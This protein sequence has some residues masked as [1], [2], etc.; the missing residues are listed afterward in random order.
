MAIS[1]LVLENFRNYSSYT[2]NSDGKNVIITAPNGTGKT[3]I[4]E[5]ISTLSPGKSLR[6]S[7]SNEITN[8][9]TNFSSW[10]VFCDISNDCEENTVG[11]SYSGKKRSRKIIKI[12]GKSVKSSIELLSKIRV[13]WLTPAMDFILASSKSERRRFL[14]RLT[15]NFFPEHALAVLNFEKANRSR[16]KLLTSGNFDEIWLNQLEKIMAEESIKIHSNRSKAI[17]LIMRELDR[18]ETK[19]LKPDLSFSGN[20]EDI[21]TS[22]P[23][24]DMCSKI[25][26]EFKALRMLDSIKG[27]NSIG[28]NKT[29]FICVNPLKQVRAE[30]SSTGEQKAMLI[31]TIIASIRALNSQFKI[32]P[33][34]LLDDIFSHL[35]EDRTINL[36]SELSSVNSQIWITTTDLFI[37]NQKNIFKDFIK[38]LL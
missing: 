34:L 30:K 35:D 37:Q 13:L 28:A 8:I 16:T 18:F 27:K 23:E 21:I 3:N 38:I 11:V 17:K 9:N 19:F 6:G 36:M 32:S 12:D 31:S 29:D 26:M 4:L 1:R 24:I 15:Y 10:T 5:A 2:L 20:L 33:V 22:T 25:C 7:D 14:D